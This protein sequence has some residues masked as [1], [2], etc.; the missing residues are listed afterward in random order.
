MTP[1]PS[2][3]EMVPGLV[4]WA[5]ASGA[6]DMPDSDA[7]RALEDL[8]EARA[9]DLD[10]ILVRVVDEATRVL[11]AD[12]GTLYLV[13]HARREVVSHIAQLAEIRQIRLAL[14]EGVAG[15]VAAHGEIVNV[16]TRDHDARFAARIDAATGYRTRSLLAAPVR[17]AHG[18]TIGVVQL[19]N[20]R[21]GDFT[22][23]DERVLTSLGARI[24][25]LLTISSLGSQLQPTTRQP[26]SYRFNQIVGDSDAMR[27]VYDRA[28]RAAR[29]DASVLVR[30]ESGS[31]KELIAR[32]VHD[33]SPRADRPF[34]VVDL[35]ALPSELAVNEL[36]GH[37]RGAY[38][39]AHGD[40]RGRVRAADGG[41]LF[42]DEVG[43]ATPEVQVRLLRLL[44][45]R[46]FFPVGASQPV[47]VDVRFVFATHRDLEQR[48]TDGLFRADL[49][50]RLRVVE[51]GLPPLRDRGPDDLDRL[52]DHFLYELARHHDRPEVRLSEA[53]RTAL[54]GHDWPG[55]VRELR[56]CIEA[57][58]VLTPSSEIAPT[59]S[60]SAPRPQVAASSSRAAPQ[61]SPRSSWRTF[62]GCS[63]N[64]TATV[65]RR[66]DVWASV[67]TPCSGSCGAT[68]SP[69]ARKRTT[70]DSARGLSEEVVGTA[71]PPTCP[72]PTRIAEDL[73]Q[74]W[75]HGHTSS[76]G[77]VCQ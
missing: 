8:L 48:V 6:D 9:V 34:V 51:I 75:L 3:A 57:A 5:L 58:V 42:L 53:A 11:D 43:D 38:T 36:F 22:A 50:Y 1:T 64:V 24:G 60:R 39:G 47:S 37:V 67:G 28:A 59:C 40:E 65:A 29:T 27:A 33:N 52:I 4:R 13:D 17:N 44:Q 14:G 26:L 7:L 30:G 21:H 71:S 35:S 77:N 63:N 72:E 69:D 68:P 49:Y 31:G 45:E 70:T 18:A 23:E 16:P 20:K 15:W 62:G 2:Y 54:H 66:H 12:R 76:H 56:N 32:A 41:T 55:N 25:E 74:T 10:G 19:L 73:R 46:S 61:R